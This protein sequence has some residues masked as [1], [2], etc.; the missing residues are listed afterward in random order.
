MELSAFNLDS[1]CSL[2]AFYSGGNSSA[3]VPSVIGWSL[4]TNLVCV[5]HLPLQ[6]TETQLNPSVSGGLSSLYPSHI[7]FSSTL[8]NPG[9][10]HHLAFLSSAHLLKPHI[11]LPAALYTTIGHG[12]LGK[13]RR[14]IYGP[15]TARSQKVKVKLAQS[16]PTVSN[17]MD[18]SIPGSSVHEIL[19][20]RILEWVAVHFSR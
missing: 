11:L 7:H 17:S 13:M 14:V 8:K 3:L 10:A 20:A 6:F 16:C 12:R 18:Y 19:R 15:P 5:L 4:G 2:L 9:L 1:Q